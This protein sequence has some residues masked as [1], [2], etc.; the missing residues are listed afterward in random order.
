MKE[1]PGKAVLSMA[2]QGGL[3]HGAVQQT[4]RIFFSGGRDEGTDGRKPCICKGYRVQ[5]RRGGRFRKAAAHW[6]GQ[7]VVAKQMKLC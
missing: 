4:E 3:L 2:A 6:D 7:I 5:R 1:F